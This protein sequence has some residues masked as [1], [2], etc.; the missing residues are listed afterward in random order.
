MFKMEESKRRKTA[1]STDLGEDAL[2]THSLCSVG[3]LRTISV[4]TGLLEGDICEPKPGFLS[5]STTAG[6]GW[7]LL[8]CG[9]V[10]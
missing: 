3:H 4:L 9:P 2:S 10:L 5:L 6:W 1:V 7:M 8:F